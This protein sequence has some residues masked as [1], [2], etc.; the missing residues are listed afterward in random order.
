MTQLR[1]LDLDLGDKIVG[2][3]DNLNPFK[4]IGENITGTIDTYVS[5]K[6]LDKDKALELKTQVELFTMK[7]EQMEIE[8]QRL[9]LELQQAKFELTEKSYQM[10]L[11]TETLPWVDA[12]HKLGR[13]LL[14]FYNTT[15][16]AAVLIIYGWKDIVVDGNTMAILGLGSAASVAYIH[17][18]GQ[19][20]KIK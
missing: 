19:G 7:G 8:L 16:N 9:K 11:Q 5:E 12:F 6:T 1:T 18:K 3:L 2:I 10:A 14:A 20:F 13:T 4:K 17:K 15:I